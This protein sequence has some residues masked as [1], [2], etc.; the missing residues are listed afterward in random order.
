M[1]LDYLILL[2]D[3]I[4]EIS[5]PLYTKLTVLNLNCNDIDNIE[6]FYSLNMPNIK[7]IL[8][9]GNKITQ[10]KSFNKLNAPNLKYLHISINLLIF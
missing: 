8:L 3:I 5:Q 2:P 9:L 1:K 6:P 7:E 10:F 4:V